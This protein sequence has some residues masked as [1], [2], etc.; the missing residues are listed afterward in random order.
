M[1][2]T[3]GM[4]SQLAAPPAP[5]PEFPPGEDIQELIAK[6]LKK[7]SERVAPPKYEVLQFVNGSVA[8][9][10]D[11]DTG[12]NEVNAVVVD[13]KAGQLELF[14]SN[15]GGTTNITP[16]T[17][18]NVGQPF[19]MLLVLKSRHFSWTCNAACLASITFQAL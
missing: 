19:Q 8:L 5:T 6:Y 11:F 1:G 15:D 7:I 17:F 13:V 3:L 10:G 12:G 2:R 14:L 16:Y 4:G 18:T 9:F